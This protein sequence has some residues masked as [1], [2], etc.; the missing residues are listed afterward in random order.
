[1]H[2]SLFLDLVGLRQPEHA[3]CDMAEDKFARYRR[4]TH[5]YSLAEV[6]LNVE[7]GSVTH[8]AM[9]THCAVACVEIRVS[10]HVLGGICLRTTRLS[11]VVKLCCTQNHQFCSHQF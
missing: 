9:R 1:A 10:A 3:L 6:A 2:G 5:A 8:A 4:Q 7:L 11:S